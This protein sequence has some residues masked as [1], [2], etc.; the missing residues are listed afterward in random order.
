MDTEGN[1]KVGRK[2]QGL[3]PGNIYNLVGKRQIISS[4]AYLLNKCHEGGTWYK[5]IKGKMNSVNWE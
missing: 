3:C 5:S 4:Q 1:T 2:R